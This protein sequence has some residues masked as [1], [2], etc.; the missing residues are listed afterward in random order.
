MTTQ[1]RT[2]REQRLINQVGQLTHTVQ[3]LT[4]QRKEMHSDLS[5]QRQDMKDAIAALEAG[6]VKDALAI[7]RDALD[8]RERTREKRKAGKSETPPG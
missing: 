1:E 2:P 8:R 7:L 3:R 5:W 6:S 4:D